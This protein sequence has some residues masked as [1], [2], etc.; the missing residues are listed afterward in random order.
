MLTPRG[1][2]LFGAD[3]KQAYVLI[4]RLLVLYFS[5]SLILMLH[6]FGL[7]C[8]TNSNSQN[9]KKRQPLHPMILQGKH[10]HVDNTPPPPPKKKKKKKKN[11]R[12]ISLL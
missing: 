4:P 9:I 5:C 2:L 3:S 12:Q 10:S 1:F 7:A 8:V 6:S 11:R